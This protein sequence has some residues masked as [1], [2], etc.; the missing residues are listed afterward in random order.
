MVLSRGVQWLSKVSWDVCWSAGISHPSL[1][2]IKGTNLGLHLG[3]LG[4]PLHTYGVRSRVWQRPLS[5]L[6]TQHTTR[7]ASLQVQQ[8][9]CN[10]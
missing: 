4:A 5:S 10:I 2:S 1:T 3:H 9:P 8:Q 6:L 7:Q